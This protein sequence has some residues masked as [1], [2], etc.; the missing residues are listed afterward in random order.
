MKCYAILWSVHDVERQSMLDFLDTIPE[1]LNWR[2]ASGTVFIVSESD[3]ERLTELVRAVK[4]NMKFLI[5]PI[6]MDD[7]QG[8]QDPKTWEFIR[9]PKAS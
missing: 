2:A 8:Y 9:N 1:I 4:L 5:T 3:V 7:I 6:E